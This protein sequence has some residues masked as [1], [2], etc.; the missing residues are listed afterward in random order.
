MAKTRRNNSPDTDVL[1]STRLQNIS[2]DVLERGEQVLW[3]CERQRESVAAMIAENSAID[4][5]NRCIRRGLGLEKAD[6][7]PH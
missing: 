7:L 2:S 4:H 6:V 3:D 1:E 5:G